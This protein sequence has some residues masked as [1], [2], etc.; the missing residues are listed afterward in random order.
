MSLNETEFNQVD[1]HVG[2]QLRLLRCKARLSQVQLS[3]KV[4]VKLPKI[5]EYES[6]QTRIGAS[7][8]FQ[9][10][11]IFSVSPEFFLGLKC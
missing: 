4:G 9:F 11:K 5:Q 2:E 3:D 1:K 6:G 7:R 10:C 8:L